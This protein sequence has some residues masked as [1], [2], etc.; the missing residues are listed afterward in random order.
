M[1]NRRD[2]MKKAALADIRDFSLLAPEGEKSSFELNENA[3][4]DL[5]IDYIAEHAAR[6]APEKEILKRIL[7]NIPTSR[8]GIEYRRAVYSEL[9]EDKK[10]C[11]ELY[12]IFDSMSFYF[13]DRPNHVGEGSTVYDLL[14]R[15]KSLE[16]YSQSVLKIIDVIKGREF[17]SEGMKTFAEYVSSI[18]NS[19]GFDEFVKDISIIGDDVSNV[20][21]MTIGVNLD[22]MFYPKEA[23][24]ISLNKYFFTRQSILKR[25]LNFHSRDQLTD[26]ELVPF[27]M[28]MHKEGLEWIEKKYT[29][30]PSPTN[31]ATDSPLMNNLNSIIERML[32][33]MTSKL[34][35]VLA[36]YVD[37]SGK[38][39]AQLAD[40]L[41]FYLRFIELEEKLTALGMPCCTGEFSEGDTVLKDFYNLKLAI[42]RL[43]GTVTDDIVCNDMEFTNEKTVQILTG[44]NRGGKTILTQGIGL[45][46]LMYQCGVFVPAA[47]AAIR[48]C[49]GIYTHFPVEEERTVSLGRLGEEAERFNEIC[50]TAGSESLLLMNESFATT[51]H[52]ESLYIAEDALKYLCC[53]GVRTCFNTHM[54]EL[55]ENADSYGKTEKAVCKA[56]SVVMESG[57]GER[58]YKISYKSP[59]GKSYA[60]DIAYKFGITFEQLMDKRKK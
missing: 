56:V 22:A 48:P 11:E 4:N 23:G 32:P 2:D 50:K 59:D 16:S 6:N 54:H 21:S 24:I 47:S 14:D 53:T 9:R 3:A 44:P 57:N 37:V 35:R 26:K 51:S 17:K 19:S 27:T 52:T 20:K 12:Y 10:L 13:S 60:H 34:K 18:Y 49:D 33:S 45:V 38:A 42:C 46:F 1:R 29:G 15:L 28:E 8:R 36:K 31:R 25:F 7:L 39:L 43:K 30:L 41:L 55:A 5:S 58:S 40:E